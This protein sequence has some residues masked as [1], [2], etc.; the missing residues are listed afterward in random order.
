MIRVYF[1]YEDPFDDAGINLSFADVPTTDPGKA[2]K[3]IQG[4]ANSGELWQVLYPDT[5]EHPYTLVASKMTFLDI[6]ELKKRLDA[7]TVLTT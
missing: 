6:S 1:V 3:R 5:K 4:A 7:G 2:F